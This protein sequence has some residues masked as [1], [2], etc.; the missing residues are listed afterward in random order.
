MT[1]YTYMG[2]Y[3]VITVCGAFRLHIDAAKSHRSRIRSHR[4]FPFRAG[5]SRRNAIIQRL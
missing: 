5:R 1:E 2:V 4:G 3:R